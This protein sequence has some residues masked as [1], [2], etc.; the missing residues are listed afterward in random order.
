MEFISL[1]CL[2]NEKQLGELDKLLM[3]LKEPSRYFALH[4]N[5]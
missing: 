2:R 4:M 5:A 3:R 1:E